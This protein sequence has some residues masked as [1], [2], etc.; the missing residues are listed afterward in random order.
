MGI[1]LSD[2]RES[3]FLHEIREALDLVFGIETAELLMER[4]EKDLGKK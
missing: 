4:L 1:E 2:E 3:Y